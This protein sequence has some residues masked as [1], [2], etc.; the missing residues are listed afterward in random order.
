M[1][2]SGSPAP[3][4]YIS[5]F[6]LDDMQPSKLMRLLSSNEEDANILSSPS[7]CVDGPGGLFPFPGTHSS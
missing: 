2:N 1:G 4:D 7:E 6:P 5:L 3:Q